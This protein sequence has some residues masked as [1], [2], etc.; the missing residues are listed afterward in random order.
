V[1][2]RRIV[3][4]YVIGIRGVASLR[5]EKTQI[6][7]YLINKPL[8]HS[9]NGIGAKNRNSLACHYVHENKGSY[10]FSAQKRQACNKLIN[11]CLAK[12]CRPQQPKRG[13]PDLYDSAIMLMKTHIEKMSETGFAIMLMKTQV[14]IFVCHYVDDN[15]AGYRTACL[16]F[17]CL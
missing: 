14:L 7:K 9:R 2:K 11:R 10:G 4:R 16:H 5:F 17:G 8:A 1:K 15:K 12:I 6:C 3:C 13:V